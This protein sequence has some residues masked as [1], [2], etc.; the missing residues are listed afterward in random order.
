[1]VVVIAG[2]KLPRDA[3]D[4]LETAMAVGAPLTILEIASPLLPSLA[5]HVVVPAL[6]P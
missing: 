2:I 4:G 5:V 3:S 1:M 6:H